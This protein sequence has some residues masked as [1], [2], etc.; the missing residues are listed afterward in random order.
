MLL[1][2]TAYCGSV[3]ERHGTVVAF[4]TAGEATK[5]YA[6]EQATSLQRVAEP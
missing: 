2:D 1:Q 6:W 3:A 4:V 5:R